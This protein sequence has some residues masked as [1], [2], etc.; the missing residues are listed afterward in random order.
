VLLTLL[1]SDA[2]HTTIGFSSA[3][4][5]HTQRLQWPTYIQ[6]DD[7]SSVPHVSR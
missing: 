6:P 4:Q 7:S 3:W 2:M 1:V 5:P